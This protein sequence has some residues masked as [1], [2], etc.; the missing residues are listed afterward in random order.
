M[1]T[2]RDQELEPISG[3]PPSLIN[4]PSG[5]FFHPRCPYVR[6]AH[7][8]IDPKLEPIPADPGHEVACLLEPEI[9]TRIW[10]GLRSGQAPAV[11][12]ALAEPLTATQPAGAPPGAQGGG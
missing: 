3:R 4:R 10:S 5:C 9:R 1:D 2:P 12:R 11:V 6:E 7:K 8:R